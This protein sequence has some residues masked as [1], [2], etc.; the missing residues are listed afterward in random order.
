[1]LRP[2]TVIIFMACWC[3]KATFA[4]EVVNP[5]NVILVRAEIL[6]CPN[7]PGILAMHRVVEGDG[8]LSVGN[9]G[10]IP[11]LGQTPLQIQSDIVD[12]VATKHAR[13]P[14]SIRVELLSSE[15]EYRLVRDEILNSLSFLARGECSRPEQSPRTIDWEGPI[16]NCRLT[17]RCRLTPEDRRA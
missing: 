13:R 10:P 4:D 6:E 16:A 1:M 9:I 7:F 15:I 8:G 5:G 14:R 12:A 11:V 2:S 3:T 17:T